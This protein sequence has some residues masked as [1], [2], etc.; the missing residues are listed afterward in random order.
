MAFN[1]Q[2]HEKNL[3]CALE[4]TSGGKIPE[5][6]V[7]MLIRILRRHSHDKLAVVANAENIIPIDVEGYIFVQDGKYHKQHESVDFE[8]SYIVIQTNT[9]KETLTG[10]P[11][12]AVYF[13]VVT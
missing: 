8:K 5:D 7:S 13:K 4:Y 1:L 10:V 11:M 6:D 3:I 12:Y 9:K 2:P